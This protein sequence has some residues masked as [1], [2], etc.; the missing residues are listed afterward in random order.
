MNA[1]A[2]MADYEAR[3]EAA[4]TA[5]YDAAPHNMKDC[6]DDARLYL[7]HAL[8]IATGLGLVEQVER[9]KKRAAEI[10]AVYNH[11]FRYVGR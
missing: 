5:M 9:L 8:Q 4:Y 2:G 10:E 1:A 11:L 3:A 7:A 6:Y